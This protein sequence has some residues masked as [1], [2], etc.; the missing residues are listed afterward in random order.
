MIR[1]IAFTAISFAFTG[2]VCAIDLAPKFTVTNVDGVPIRRP[3]FVDGEKKF[4]V[5]T[6]HE[7]E[8][9]E[10]EG[11]ASFGFTKFPRAVMRL[12]PSPLTADIPFD[13]LNLPRYRQ[14][15]SSFL[16]PESEK[17]AIESEQ[18]DVLPINDWQSHRF[19]VR[20]ELAGTPMRESITFLNLSPQQQIVVQIR[21]GDTDFTTVTARSEDI[22][23]RWHEIVPGTEVA[24][25]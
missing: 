14:S 22:L 2:A 10:Y 4:A 3:Y 13:D 18:R 11:S 9:R 20:Y 6:D 16:M 24:G 7:T 5:T 17:V 1:A 19:V 15:I 21:A 23:R 8:L 12:R 25:N